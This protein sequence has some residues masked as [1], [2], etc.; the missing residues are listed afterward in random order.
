MTL[1]IKE[2]RRLARECG[3][4]EVQFNE[5]S[6]VVAFLSEDDTRFNVYYTTGTVATYLFHPRQGKAQL[7]RRNVSLTMLKEIFETPRIHTDFGYHRRHDGSGAVAAGTMRIKES[8]LPTL[9]RKKAPQKNIKGILDDHERRR[10]EKRKREEA[11]LQRQE[12]ER[13]RQKSIERENRKNEIRTSRGAYGSW[14]LKETDDMKNN[15]TEYTCCVAVGS[16]GVHLCLYDDGSFAYS[17]GI[18]TN[19]YKLLHTRA[20]SHPS[21]D[22][23]AMGS[24][25]R[26]Y[27]RFKNGK[28]EW[29]GPQNLSDL[30]Q[31][32]TRRVKSIAFGEDDEDYFVVFEDGGYK[33]VGCPS[34][35]QSKIEA[36][37]CRGDLEKVTLGPNGEWGLWAQ[38][39][40]AWW[41]NVG[42]DMSDLISSVEQKDEITDL[43]FGNDGY[44]FLRYR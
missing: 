8:Q 13:R 36:R 5:T 14:S 43:L 31:K 37:E 20:L 23:V 30:L 41:G 26:Y 18:T 4:K 17:S 29:V 34:G 22:Y 1:P 12:E 2:V 10:E 44:Y 39:G 9:T 3:L 32:E 24:M 38:N 7:F 25:D 42:T 19:L 15:F 40:R 33:Y 27:I 21:P 11:E 28:S 16:D 6:R 35:L